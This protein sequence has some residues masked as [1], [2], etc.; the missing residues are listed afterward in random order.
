MSAP[1]ADAPA[2]PPTLPPQPTSV[3]AK[4][5]P[6]PAPKRTRQRKEKEAAQEKKKDKEKEKEKE[7]KD[8]GSQSAQNKPTVSSAPP[9]PTLHHHYP[10]APGPIFQPYPHPYPMMNPSY[11]IGGS[12]YGQHPHPQYLAQ[13]PQVA[14]P[15]NAGHPQHPQYAYPMHPAA[16][17]SYPGYPQYHQPMMMYPPTPRTGPQSPGSPIQ[18]QQSAVPPPLPPASASAASASGGKRKRKVNEPGRN[19]KTSDDETAAS[20]SDAPRTQSSRAQQSAAEGKKRTKTQRACDSCRSRK[21]RCDILSEADPPTCQHCKQYSFECT[22]FLPITETRFKKKKA[23]HQDKASKKDAILPQP[24]SSVTHDTKTKHDVGIIGPTSPA[25]L[26]HS[27]ASVAAKVYESYDQ[28]HNHTFTVG[29]SGDGF[30]RIHKPTA[31][32]QQASH[33]R[34]VFHVEPEVIQSLVNA[35]FTDIAPILPIVTKAEFLASTNPPPVLLYSMCLVAAARREVDPAV[36]DAIRHTVNSIIKSEDVLSDAKLVNVQ[37]LLILS[38]SGDCHSQFVPTALS[39]LWIRLG[40]AIRMAQD[41]G[42]HRAESVS[43]DIEQRRRLWAACLILD[44]WSSIAY[45]HPYMI[46]VLDCDARLPSSGDLHDLYLDEL[47]RLSIILGRVQKTI[48]TPSGLNFTTDEMLHDLLTDI[49]RWKDG[50]PEHLRFKGPDSHQHA[51]LL[52][53]LYSCVCMMFWRVFMRIS[54]TVPAQLKFSLTVEQWSELVKLTAECID[55]LDAHERLY[56]VWLIVAYASTSLALVQYHTFI[57]RKDAEAQSKLKKLRDCVRRWES[58]ISPDHMSTRRK[59]SEIISLL[60]EATQGPAMPIEAPALNPTGG[61]KPK[62]PVTLDYRRDPTRP[63]G[64]VFVAQGNSK[65]DFQDLPE[66]TVI[67]ASSDDD[68]PGSDDG[69]ESPVMHS[70]SCDANAQRGLGD[71]EDRVQGRQE[72]GEARNVPPTTQTGPMNANSG[73]GSGS[74]STPMVTFTPLN[75]GGS[76]GRGSQSYN[77][78]PAMN[79]QGSQN[80]NVQVMNMLDASQSGS[81]MA[82]LALADNG[83]LEGLPGGMFDWNQWDTFFSRF[84]GQG[85][86]VPSG[87][88]AHQGQ[89]AQQQQAQAQGGTPSP[90]NLPP[91]FSN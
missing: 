10:T 75:V 27:Q 87:F 24:S 16:Y 44:R 7:K 79:V 55:W 62:A 36:F 50:L 76:A 45:G 88:N 91:R 84:S 63:G 33:A 89:H 86:N 40:T 71:H 20:N 61:V 85:G 46:D 28:R 8:S 26:L 64:G 69:N 66:G 34:P 38:M 4:P 25:Y 15:P 30:I 72:K 53:I 77:V 35:Y 2:A 43:H 47:V 78:N 74:G 57:R 83:F 11:P 51:G 13:H 9:P 29:D 23:A 56:D 1:G 81:S 5:P 14:Q 12:P 32:E 59:T 18:Q 82:D 70:C 80:G 6:P 73:M 42:L 19:D 21:I 22:F 65:D 49:Q 68:A 60:Y 67:S 3:P 17:S 52:H 54:Y 58:A 41:L 37:A 31:E 48:Y 90:H 39:S